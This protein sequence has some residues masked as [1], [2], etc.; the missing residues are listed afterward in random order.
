MSH[1]GFLGFCAVGDTILDF[2]FG[3]FGAAFFFQFAAMCFIKT[4]F[5]TAETEASLILFSFFFGSNGVAPTEFRGNKVVLSGALS[6]L[7]HM[8]LSS[9]TTISLNVLSPRFA[10]LSLFSTWLCI[11]GRVSFSINC[12]ASRTKAFFL[13][14]IY[15]LV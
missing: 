5:V 8:S 12:C 9:S 14:H 1:L 3:N 15:R 10:M 13:K 2:N 7:R 4:R 6:L 11:L